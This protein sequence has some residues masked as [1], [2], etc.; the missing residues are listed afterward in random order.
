MSFLIGLLSTYLLVAF[1]MPYLRRRLL[2]QPNSRSSHFQPT[3][4]GGGLAFVLVS[5]FSSVWALIFDGFDMFCMIFHK[6]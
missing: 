1:L 3:P 5:F 2:D 4:R 6:F